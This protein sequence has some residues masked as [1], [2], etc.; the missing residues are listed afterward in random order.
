MEERSFVNGFFGYNMIQS[1]LVGVDIKMIH[2]SC[3]EAQTFSGGFRTKAGRGASSFAISLVGLSDLTSIPFSR[4]SPS[5]DLTLLVKTEDAPKRQSSA[6]EYPNRVCSMVLNDCLDS[7]AST[8]TARVNAT[9]INR[10]ENLF[11]IVHQSIGKQIMV[12]ST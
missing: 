10:R 9:I 3:W 11:I 5:V 2:C 7:K 12:S 6:D 8:V 4:S 1:R